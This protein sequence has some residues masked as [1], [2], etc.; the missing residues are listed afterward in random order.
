MN[1]S[2]NEPGET[3][4]RSGVEG[5]A[6]RPKELMSIYGVHIADV[7]ENKVAA[8]NGIATQDA[9]AHEAR[10]ALIWKWHLELDRP[11]RFVCRFQFVSSA[12]ELDV[13]YCGSGADQHKV[14][15]IRRI[16]GDSLDGKR[17]GVA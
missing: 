13:L 10:W 8:R 2:E 9:A 17:A 6:E 7:V 1:A 3:I 15:S 16:L 12:N 14:I 5:E 4:A 11:K